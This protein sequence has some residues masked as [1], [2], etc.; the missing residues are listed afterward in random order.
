MNKKQQK[1]SKI[2]DDYVESIYRFIFIKV[3]SRVTAEDL[4]SE[5]FLRT[6][7]TFQQKEKEKIKNPKAFL[8]VTARHLVVDF[9]RTRDKNRTL[10]IED[11]EDIADSEQQLEEKEKINSDLAL[12]QQKL[13]EI[14]DNYQDVIIWRYIDGLSIGEIS[15]ILDKSKGATRVLIHRAMGKLREQLKDQQ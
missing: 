6:W 4:T 5:V 14:K 12:I 10:P 15:Q 13:K 8:Y 3:S 11:N 2:Y 7:Q 9:Y 1:F